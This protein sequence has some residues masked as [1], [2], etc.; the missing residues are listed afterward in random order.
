MKAFRTATY[1]FIGIVTTALVALLMASGVEAYALEFDPTAGGYSNPLQSY[2]Q[3]GDAD[4]IS[5]VLVIVNTAL[6][7]LGTV[8][9]VL[10][11]IAGF[12]WL[13]AA[14]VEEKITKAK[15]I[16]KGAVIGLVIVFGSYGIAQYVFTAIRVATNG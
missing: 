8:T 10:F 4:P 5:I 9:L 16:M 6:I 1:R 11:I 13:T 3:L 7:F 15:D 2:T 14:G 12:M